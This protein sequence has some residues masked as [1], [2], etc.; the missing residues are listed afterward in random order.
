MSAELRLVRTVVL[1]NERGLVKVSRYENIDYAVVVE[2][3]VNSDIALIKVISKLK[4]MP[5][6]AITYD[7]EDNEYK[8]RLALNLY[9]KL[10]AFI[11]C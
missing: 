1:K 8:I 2:N 7:Y 10:T 5:D 11:S 9:K 6:I 3:R 4:I